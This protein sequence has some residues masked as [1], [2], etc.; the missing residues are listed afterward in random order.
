MQIQL[1]VHIDDNLFHSFIHL[2]YLPYFDIHIYRT[3]NRILETRSSQETNM[4]LVEGT[5]H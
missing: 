2:V 4:L 1:Y 3:T 5:P